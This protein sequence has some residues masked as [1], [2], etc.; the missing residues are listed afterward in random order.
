MPFADLIPALRTPPRRAF[1]PGSGPGLLSFPLSHP[2]S[3]LAVAGSPVRALSWLH[4]L[5]QGRARCGR[6][7][8]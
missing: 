1:A 3:V 5:L 4:P 8:R 6:G 7:F 2:G